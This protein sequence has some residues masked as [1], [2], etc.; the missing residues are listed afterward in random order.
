MQ[1]SLEN[2]RCASHAGS[3]YDGNPKNLSSDLKNW[4]DKAE[5]T[6][7]P[8]KMKAVMGP[9]A[10]YKF[11]GHVSAFGY[12]YVQKFSSTQAWKTVFLL[13][14]SHKVG[15]EGC[16]LSPCTT[17]ET[18]IGNFQVNHQIIEDLKNNKLVK[19]LESNKDVDE[20]E[21]S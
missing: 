15:F 10:G 19:F 13:G 1:Q 18:P 12:K 3:W 16:A 11:C 9:H 4:L 8:T 6:N 2:T 21:H 7:N 5:L 20:A 17:W 14:P